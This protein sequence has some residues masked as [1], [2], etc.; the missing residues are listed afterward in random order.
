MSDSCSPVDCSPP[1][2]SVHGISQARILEWVAVCFS[3]GLAAK[4]DFDHSGAHFLVRR[5]SFCALGGYEGRSPQPTHRCTT[6]MQEL[7]RI[8]EMDTLVLQE[9][10]FPSVSWIT[11]CKGFS[12]VSFRFLICEGTAGAIPW[13]PGLWALDPVRRKTAWLSLAWSEHQ[14][15]QD[16]KFPWKRKL[17]AKLMTKCFQAS[18]SD[19]SD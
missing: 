12:P 16:S 7:R 9:P 19:L 6:V 17:M 3:V 10:R 5:K 11:L 18:P 14:V 2:S 8:S 4:G 1:V 15:T 13:L